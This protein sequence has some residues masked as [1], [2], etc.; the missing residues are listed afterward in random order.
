[1]QQKDTITV[2][3]ALLQGRKPV[4][5]SVTELGDSMQRCEQSWLWGSLNGFGLERPQPSTALALGSLIHYTMADWSA[6]HAAFY[7]PKGTIVLPTGG[8]WEVL[9]DPSYIAG[10]KPDPIAIFNRHYKQFEQTTKERYATWRGSPM[11]DS[12]WQVYEDEVGE[13]GEAMVANYQRYY[14]TPYPDDCTLLSPELTIVVPLPKIQPRQRQFYLEGTIDMFLL[15]ADGYLFPW[16]HKT[17][18]DHPSPYELKSNDQ[19]TSYCWITQEEFP[20]YIIGGFGYNGFWKRTEI[21]SRM[22]RKDGSSRDQSDLFHQEYLMYSEEQVANQGQTMAFRA[23]KAWNL[24]QR[25][26]RFGPHAID[27]SRWYPTCPGC[28]FNDICSSLFDGDFGEWNDAAEQE[29]LGEYVRRERTP[30]WRIPL[31]ELANAASS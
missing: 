15:D 26:R 19:F 20:D 9:R 11:D 31:T 17:Y 25:R 6:L 21:T 10:K 14:G 8:D 27:K 7:Q 23:V 1:M 2:P 28:S 4:I 30:A 12:E 29:A 5:F 13:L 3:L 22:R 24:L 16:D 18:N